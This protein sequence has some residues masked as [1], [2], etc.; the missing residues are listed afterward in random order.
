MITIAIASCLVKPEREAYLM[1]S[2]DS[3]RK[4]FPDGEFLVAFDKVGKEIPGCKTYVHQLG[5]GHS[6]NWCLQN[7]K[8]DLV[9]Q[10]EDDWQTEAA[11]LGHGFGELREKSYRVQQWHKE[12]PNIIVRLDN[13]ANPDMIKWYHPGWN[14]IGTD[15]HNREMLEL[16]KC[17]PR[18]IGR[19]FNQYFYCNRP[20]FKHKDLHKTVGWYP[21]QV[22]V[23]TV[24]LEMGRTMILA[25]KTRVLAYNHNSFVH[26]G[27]I[28]ARQNHVG[29][30]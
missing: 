9:L 4:E 8:H 22:T 18:D 26:V 29:R 5:L 6:W 23:P 15:G 21:E 16:N 24:E 20:Q 25:P 14:R 28:Q 1:Q 30:D 13:V 27:T 10:T 7:A 11:F 19:G 2:I 12:D 17:A 3:I